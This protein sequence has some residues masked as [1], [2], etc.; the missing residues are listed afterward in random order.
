[1]KKRGLGFKI[2][3]DQAE[4]RNLAGIDRRDVR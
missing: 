1:M 3:G 2:L 4:K